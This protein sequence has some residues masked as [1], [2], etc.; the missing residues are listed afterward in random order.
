[1]STRPLNIAVVGAGFARG[2][3]GRENWGVRTHVP[4]LRSMPGLFNVVALCT[5]H[6]ETARNA[7]DHFGVPH[8]YDDFDALMRLPGLDAVTVVVRP[9][10]HYAV[11][12]AALAAGKHVYCEWPLA[13]GANEARSMADLA[14]RM[15]VVTA[16]G[17]QGYFWPAAA[18]LRTMIADGYIGRPLPFGASMFVSNYIAPRP[19]HRQWLFQA[20]EGGNAA[21]RAGHLL[22]RITSTLGEVTA[23]CADL[24]TLVPERPQLGGG[25]L[26]GDQVD[27]M[28]FLL[29]LEG[30]IRGTLQ[31]S[32]TAWFGTG[33]RMEVYGTD[34]A[35]VLSR[36]RPDE[37]STSQAADP[38]YLEGGDLFGARVDR[39]AMAAGNRAPE[40]LLQGLSAIAVDDPSE[41]TVPGTPSTGSAHVVRR[42]LRAFGQAIRSGTPFTPDFRAGLRLH[43]VL[44]AAEQAMRE[45]RWVLLP[46]RG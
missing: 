29:E 44:E 28:S 3:D 19:A 16:T 35:L 34:G 23:I 41:E 39:A 25:S 45:R 31:V 46:Q 40:S 26:A 33:A 18:R 38:G 32:Y 5:S 17:T 12:M 24:S 1:V 4:A 43:E 11:T 13:L 7:A 37:P 14:E 30:G 36:V 10:L 2:A 6:M 9:R 42:A 22:Q 15:G 21:Y 27:N 20:S 8:A